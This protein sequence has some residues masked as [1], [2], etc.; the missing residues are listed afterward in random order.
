MPP[1]PKIDLHDFLRKR[2]PRFFDLLE[3]RKLDWTRASKAYITA[4]DKHRARFERT[5]TPFRIEASLY[6]IIIEAGNG[7]KTAIRTFEY[8]RNLFTR[9]NE[10]ITP[11]EKQLLQRILFGVVSNIDKK[12]LNFLGELSVLNYIKQTKPVTLVRT[13][14]PVFPDKPKGVSIDFD[15]R[16]N[17]TGLIWPVEVVNLHL[18]EKNTANDETKER[19]LNQKIGE[20]L[21]VTGIRKTNAFTLAPVVRGTWRQ[22]YA[23]KDYYARRNPTFENTSTPLAFVP[24]DDE[25]GNPVYKFGTIDVI[26]D[27]STAQ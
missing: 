19:L 17:L 26:F 2:F 13:E 8:I 11:E 23:L 4:F 27:G 12:Y 14:R 15:F 10:L 18:D 3:G 20:K 21:L 22:I 1:T 6:N 16:N 7:D 5:K 9:L 24:F 25:Q